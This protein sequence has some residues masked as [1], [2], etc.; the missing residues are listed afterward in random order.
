MKIRF[1]E[2]FWKEQAI[3]GMRDIKQS[4]STASFLYSG[5]ADALIQALAPLSFE[6]ITLTD[7]DIEDVFLHYYTKEEE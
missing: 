4:D 6:D 5:R 1:D 2:A 3:E 7:P